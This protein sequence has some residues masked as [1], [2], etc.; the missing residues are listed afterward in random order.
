MHKK[1]FWL[2]SLLVLAAVLPVIHLVYQVSSAEGSGVSV[3]PKTIR[4]GLVRQ[5]PEIEFSIQGRYIFF[6]GYNGEFIAEAEPHKRYKVERVDQGEGKSILRLSCSGSTVSEFRGPLLVRKVN[7]EAS[8]LSGSG[9]LVK[10]TGGRGLVAVNAAGEIKELPENMSKWT[11]ISASGMANL[12]VQDELQLVTLYTGNTSK[13]YRGNFDFRLD[14]T[15]ITAINDLPLEEYLYGVVPSEMPY[16]WPEEALK[17]QAV[18]ARTYALYSRGQYLAYG[19]DVL[20]TQKNQV[21]HGYDHETPETNKAVEET[22]GQVLTYNDRLI[23]AVFHSS[24]GGFT[25]NCDEVWKE[26]IPYLTAKKDPYD[27]NEKHYDWSVTMSADQLAKQLKS[28]GYL[29]SKILDINEV[30]RDETG[31]RVKKI[32]VK[33][34]DENGRVKEEDIFNADMVRYALGLK[35]SL[36]TM[37]KENDEENNLLSVTFTGS[38]WGHGLGMSQ[39]GARGMAWEGYSYQDILEYYYN[40]AELE[41]NYGE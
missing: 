13:R 33:G 34:I 12:K 37:K 20:A 4:I 9:A 21:Y 14:E 1:S 23:L 39:Y 16:D 15:G 25:G 8:I 17:A 22:K 30:Q 11:L 6:K 5:A 19:F 28:K 18:V 35:S 26:Y 36:F 40:G 32:Q 3:T 29:Y 31:A 24:S 2:I 7:Q 10:R 38:G 27:Y 41:Y